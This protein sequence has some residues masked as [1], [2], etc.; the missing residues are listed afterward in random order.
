M[1]IE[2][3]NKIN[4]LENNIK[5]NI[6]KF[7]TNSLKILENKLLK[8][9]NSNAENIDLNSELIDNDFRM[10]IEKISTEIRYLEHKNKNLQIQI[11]KL[12]NNYY[13]IIIVIVYAIFKDL[14]LFLLYLITSTHKNY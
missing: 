7:V 8:K 2:N 1:I 13:L 10:F 12:N 11:E 9:I 4:D 6:K 14:F 5:N 3:N